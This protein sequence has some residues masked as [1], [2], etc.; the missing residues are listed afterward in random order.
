[1]VANTSLS[2]SLPPVDITPE[3]RSA[4]VD[5]LKQVLAAFQQA[6]KIK[7]EISYQ[8]L[9]ENPQALYQFIQIFRAN[10]ELADAIVRSPDG[11]LV[12]DEETELVC[13][14]SLAQIQR[15][16]ILTAAKRHFGVGQPQAKPQEDKKGGLGSL[17]RKQD[18]DKT[19]ST[20]MSAEERKLSELAKYLAYDWQIPLLQIYRDSLTFQHIMELGPCI[21]LL[22]DAK[23]IAQ[24]GRLDPAQIRKARQVVH[25]D[26][27]QLLSENPKAVEGVIYWNA[28]MFKFFHNLLKEKCWAFFARDQMFFNSVAAFEKAKLRLFGDLLLSITPEGLSEFD[29]LNLD[30]T[31][32]ILEAF[33]ANFGR[34]LPLM[35]SQKSF[36]FETLHRM[37]ESFVHLRKGSEQ[38]KIYADLTCKAMLPTLQ[39]WINKVKAELAQSNG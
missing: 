27:V 14:V 10:R 6:K 23:A 32:A 18:T 1:M 22:R 16:L 7:A 19:A 36:A 12:R 30:K 8:M 3:T 17:F 15:L 37:V 4:I 33:R 28:D 13:G 38:I 24:A 34:D 25:D 29:R 31:A 35:L 2:I 5:G 26:F 11:A 9:I 20:G 21:T 39:P